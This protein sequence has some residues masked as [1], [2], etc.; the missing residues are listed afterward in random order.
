MK[1]ERTIILMVIVLFLL[2]LLIYARFNHMEQRMTWQRIEGLNL[3][4]DSLIATIKDSDGRYRS[5]TDDLRNIQERVDL[6][7]GEKNDFLAKL[8]NVSRDLEGLR[9]SLAV[10]NL[11]N[12]KKIVELGAISVKKH[13][14]VRR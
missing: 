10:T 7:E 1:S 13:E 2:I 3:R 8:D 6:M 14:K 12:S 11:D 5:Y 9:A 4:L